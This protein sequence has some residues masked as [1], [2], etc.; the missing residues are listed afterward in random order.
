MLDQFNTYLVEIL[1]PAGPFIAMGVLGIFCIVMTLPFLLTKK[2]DPFD[3]LAGSAVRNPTPKR[4]SGDQPKLELREK[5]KGP[6]L[7]K[8]AA[9]LEPQ[10]QQEFSDRRLKL[11][12]AGYRTK[13]AVRTFHFLQLVLGLAGLLLG[14]VYTFL[15]TGGTSDLKWLAIQTLGP[16]FVGYYAPIYWVEKRRGTRQE[17]I[18]NGFPDSLDLMLVCIEAGQSL[19]QAVQRVAKEIAPSAPALSEEFTIVANEMR[20]GKERPVVLRDMAERCDCQDI[21]AFVTVMIQSATFGT[22]LGEALRVYASEM[23]DKRVTRAE[24]K[25]NKLP[26]KMTLCTMMFTVPPL[27]VIMVGPSVFDIYVHMVQK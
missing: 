11:I 7:D 5:Q 23:R 18:L 6:N 9:Y 2:E 25:A 8:F 4:G 10:D 14:T 13:G 20:A 16:G 19:D 12:Q 26:T 24:E 21:S 3:R 27:L 15:L 1:G 17:E 22:S